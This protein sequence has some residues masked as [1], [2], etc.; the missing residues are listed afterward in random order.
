MNMPPAFSFLIPHIEIL[1]TS[2]HHWTGRHLIDH[3]ATAESAVDILNT[4]PFAVVSHDI[5]PDPIFNYANQLALELFRMDWDEFTTLPSR[6]SAEPV[7]QAD[8]ARLLEAV[9]R[10]G[11][12]DDYTGIR[13]AK[14]GQRF[15]IKN[16]TVWNLFSPGNA[17]YGQAALIRN[18]QAI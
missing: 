14:T 11:Y 15:M 10:N 2:Y 5:K 13:I 6:L 1:R 18:W 8:R 9:T 12:I 16:A 3:S 17:F 4:A 7:N